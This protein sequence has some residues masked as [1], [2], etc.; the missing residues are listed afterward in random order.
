MTEPSHDAPD[1]RKPYQK[2]EVVRLRLR[3]DGDNVLG[4]CKTA[5]AAPTTVGSTTCYA[6]ATL[7]S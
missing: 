3:I 7:G 4:A 5:I 6:C 1:R 2:P